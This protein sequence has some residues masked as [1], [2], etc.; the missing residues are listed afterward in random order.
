MIPLAPIPDAVAALRTA[1]RD[2]LDP[3]A[4]WARAVVPVEHGQLLLMPAEWGRYAGIKVA[5]VAPGNPARGLPRIQGS[6]LLLDAETLTPLTM[7]D[8]AALTTLRTAAVSALAVDALAVPDASRLVVFGTGPQARSHIAAIR[9]VRPVGEVVVIGRNADRA[10]T[11]ASSV[12]AKAGSAADVAM[13]DVVVCATTARTPLF[14]GAVLRPD[15]T[16]VAVG[17]HEPTARE[18]DDTT[19][20]S[21]TVVVEARSAALREAGDVVRPMAAGRFDPD[22]LVDLASLVR[23][24]ATFDRDRPRLFKSVGMAWEDLVIAASSWEKRA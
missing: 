9:A 1:L 23:G 18:V 22:T 16:V 20:C 21:S 6:Y 11:F 3:E 17:S 7:L 14:D 5:T 8:A 2:G 12:D 24:A 15:V 13:A 4:D 19:V 10:R